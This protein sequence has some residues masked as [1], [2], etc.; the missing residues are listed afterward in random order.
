MPSPKTHNNLRQYHRW[1][2]FFLSG[3][4]AVYATSGILLIFR[5]TEILQYEQQELRQL[6]PELST[7]ELGNV[8]RIREFE[9]LER[10]NSTITFKQGSYDLTTGLATVIRK[11]YHPAIQN[12]VNLHKATTDSPLYWLNISF[13]L[14]LLFFV[15]TAFLMFLP[16]TKL[17]KNSLKIAGVG[18]VFA[19]LVV[20]YGS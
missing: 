2:G 3:I 7:K 18:F 14:S 20:V 6:E 15:T 5:N 12:L 8:L 19:I 10:N 1:L 11:D 13:A 4:M 16:K 9:V 17:F